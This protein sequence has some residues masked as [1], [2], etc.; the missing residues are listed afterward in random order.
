MDRVY[1]CSDCDFCYSNET[2]GQIHICVN[3]KS[4]MLGQLVDWLG[5]AEEDMECVVVNGKD[6][7]ELFEENFE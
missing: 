7:N 6:H 1:N 5:L 2:M 4:D 3:G